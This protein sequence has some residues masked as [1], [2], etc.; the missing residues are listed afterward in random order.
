MII[1]S[2]DIDLCTLGG[3][4]EQQV[5]EDIPLTALL[6]CTRSIPQVS[7]EGT[8]C[9]RTSTDIFNTSVSHVSA[10]ERQ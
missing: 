1:I 6:W 3:L 9:V 4:S 8:K 5:L 7:A 2:A 10:N